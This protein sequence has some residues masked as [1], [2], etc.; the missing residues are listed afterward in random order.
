MSRGPAHPSES[1]RDRAVLRRPVEYISEAAP[2]R[3]RPG[4][5]DPNSSPRWGE[6][7]DAQSSSGSF[8]VGLFRAVSRVAVRCRQVLEMTSER[9]EMRCCYTGESYQRAHDA[10]AALRPGEPPIPCPAGAVQQQFEARV[11][12]AVLEGRETANRYPL[13]IVEVHPAPGQVSLVVESEE[14]AA[15]LLFWLL[16]SY[17]AE[18]GV[19]GI[20]GLRITSRATTSIELCQLGT[21]AALRL[22]GL[23]AASWRR[24]EQ[25]CIDKWLD[26]DGVVLCWRSSPKR[27]TRQERELQ[28]ERDSSDAPMARTWPAGAWL[29]SGLLRRLPL[30]HSVSTAHT[31]DGYRGTHGTMMRWCL[32]LSHLPRQ[33]F[34]AESLAGALS[35]HEFGLPVQLVRFSDEIG[36][37]EDRGHEFTLRDEART[38]R[39]EI[40]SLPSLPLGLPEEPGLMEVLKRRALVQERNQL[41]HGWKISFSSGT[42]RPQQ[43]QDPEPGPPHPFLRAQPG[44]QAH[45]PAEDRSTRGTN[46]AD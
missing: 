42:R 25:A 33:R 31:A 36:D 34:G 35:H 17:N 14:R 43:A 22:R 1:E 23:P 6:C 15:E 30:L 18:N 38:A 45:S 37:S 13:G 27:W 11:F 40:R 5:N 2:R 21:G 46:T 29:G 3:S 12:A 20:P 16:P 39:L 24:A 19:I 9:T 7:A 32:R 41:R 44:Q 26:L 28:E 8:R 10:L 4:R